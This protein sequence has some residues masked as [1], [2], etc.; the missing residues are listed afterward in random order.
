MCNTK[1]I[2]GKGV[3]SRS[4]SG[5]KIT[6]FSAALVL[7]SA[8]SSLAQTSDKD[9]NKAIEDAK[10]KAQKELEKYTGVKKPLT[11][12]EVIR[13]LKEALNVGTNNSTA[14]TSKVDGFNKNS[15][16]RIPF[17]VEAEKIKN[18]VV[19]LGMQKQ[20]DDFVLTMNRAAEEASKE[21]APVISGSHQGHEHHRWIQDPERY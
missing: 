11:N 13:G 5:K 8:F 10:K 2:N 12:D 1:K 3:T 7:M 15:L 18:T 4:I 16:I 6:L 21:A 9:L 19:N 17:P 14:S 20:V